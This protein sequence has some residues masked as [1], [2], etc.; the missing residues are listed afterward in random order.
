M[1]HTNED[2][3]FIAQDLWDLIE[4]IYEEPTSSKALSTWTT[5]KEKE[6][7]QNKQKDTNF[8]NI[9]GQ[10]LNWANL[11]DVQYILVITF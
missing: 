3:F 4:E 5:K 10:N 8:L 1:E 7:K 9:F 6:Y 11:K 2:I